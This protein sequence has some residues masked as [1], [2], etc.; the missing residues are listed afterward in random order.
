MKRTLFV[1]STVLF[2][3]LSLFSCKKDETNNNSN[4]NDGGGSSAGYVDLGL[5]CGTKWK[6]ANET[7][8]T[9]GLYTY[10]EAVSAFGNK[11][12]TKEQWE[13]L[14]DSC[15]WEWQNNDCKVTGPNGNSIVLPAAGFRHCD[16]N[17]YVDYVGYNGLY[18]TS[19][20]INSDCAWDFCFHSDAVGT[21]NYSDHCFGHSVRLVQKQYWYKNENS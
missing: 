16:G 20:P 4:N 12:P 2:F 11:L 18:W 5:P 9:N 8:G 14:Y 6:S 1:L 19:T 10:D 17:V 15:T 7:G 3:A 13:E 21:Y